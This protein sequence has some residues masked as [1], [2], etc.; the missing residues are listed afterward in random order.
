MNPEGLQNSFLCVA[1]YQFTIS[2]ALDY[3]LPIL[4]RQLKNLKSYLNSNSPLYAFVVEC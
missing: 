1:F 2:C 4:S 3:D